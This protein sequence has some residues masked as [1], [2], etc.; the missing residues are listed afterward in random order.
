MSHE[1]CQ[2]PQYNTLCEKMCLHTHTQRTTTHILC[3]YMGSFSVTKQG[4]NNY[5]RCVREKQR[6]EVEFFLIEQVVV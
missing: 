6:T 1:V 4:S 3:I 2:C 5:F